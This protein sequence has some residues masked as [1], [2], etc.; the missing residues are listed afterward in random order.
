MQPIDYDVIAPAY[1]RRYEA[2]QFDGID[3]CVRTFLNGLVTGAVA[4]IGC[5]TGHWLRAAS[6]SPGIQLV[7]G[8][9][10]S[11]GML[12]RARVQAPAAALVRGTAH[13]LPWA[14]ASFDRVFCINA[15][16]HFPRTDAFVREC[17]RVLRPDGAFLTVGLDPHTRLDSW[18]VY[19]Y[20]PAARAADLLRYPAAASIQA[21]LRTAGFHRIATTVAQ[22]LPAR[23]SF[24]A[25]EQKGLIDR[26]STSQLM[27]ITDSEWESGIARLR[28]DKPELSAD[29][30]L[31][32][33]TGTLHAS[34]GAQ[35]ENA[36]TARGR[37]DT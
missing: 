22:H 36:T 10:L 24:R 7:A 15:L 5:G 25:A 31:Y 23:V 8:L 11:A 19:E 21:S 32:A 17:A 29:L 16:H 13:Q 6:E 33:T 37:A 12:G 28:R 1:E 26:R 18:W 14:D 35:A 30:R 20:F 9:D 27:V 4:E 34:V 2:N 3:D